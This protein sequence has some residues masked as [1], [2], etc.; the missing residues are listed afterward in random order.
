MFTQIKDSLKKRW[1]VAG[2]AGAMTLGV[3]GTAF[4]ALTTDQAKEVETLHQQM[5]DL[6]KQV[7]QKYVEYGQITPE[8]AKAVT[9]RMEAGFKAR[10]EAG[11]ANCVPGQGRW[12]NAQGIGPQ[13]KGFGPGAGPG[14]RGGFGPGRGFGPGLGPNAQVTPQQ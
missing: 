6:R 9:D 5:L 3:V 14:F 7:V 11:F 10:Q 2:L 1:M 13:G 12:G 4:A 8:Q